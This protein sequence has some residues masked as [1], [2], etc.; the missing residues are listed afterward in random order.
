MRSL[1]STLFAALMMVSV[2]ALAE[3]E[4]PPPPKIDPGPP[5]GSCCRSALG[6]EGASE[7][8]THEDGVKEWTCH[9]DGIAFQRSWEGGLLP[10][11]VLTDRLTGR[12]GT[13]S[14]W[15]DRD[16]PTGSGDYELF[17]DLVETKQLC[18]KPLA[19]E[20]QTTN[21]Q[22]DW[23]ASQSVYHCDL[24]R[25]GYCVNREQAPG[26][27]CEDFRVRY[28]CPSIYLSPASVVFIP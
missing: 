26:S 11:T 28:L 15:F 22:I 14:A 10:Y 27:S 5:S 6:D 21:G 20:C 25:G 8:R 16:R 4:N 1:M 23:T 17:K 19:I 7:E 3:Q 9:L 2:S 24:S 12:I 13:W 18:A